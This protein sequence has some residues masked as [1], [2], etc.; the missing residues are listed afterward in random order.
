MR[1]DVKVLSAAACGIMAFWRES[2][3]ILSSCQN[4]PSYKSSLVSTLETRG[5][6]GLHRVMIVALPLRQG[7]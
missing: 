7:V 3:E 4:L 6:A 2:R 1:R 5:K